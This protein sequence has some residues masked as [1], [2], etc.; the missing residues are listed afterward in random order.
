MLVSI[1][2]ANEYRAKGQ[3]LTLTYNDE[4]RP[5]GLKHSDFASFMKRLRFYDSTP[6]VKF[7]IA[8]EYGEKSGREHF[9]ILIYNH[10]YDLEQISRAWNKGFVY[11]GTLTPQSIKYVS[12]YVCKRGYNPDSGKRPPYG[13]TSV[14]LP[15]GMSIKEITRMCVTGKI[16][17][18]G[19]T[20][21]APAI[22]R[23]RYNDIWKFL[24]SERAEYNFRFEKKDLTP[25]Y[26][27]GIMNQRELK[28]ICK[29]VRFV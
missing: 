22:W 2:A 28:R 26:V 17:Y 23:R 5:Q 19:R 1:Y 21:A 7:H 16:L 8:G 27:S 24:E 15:D 13:R 9:H 29:K 25:E 12:G 6:G 3:F 14:N 10:R 20:F 18:N 11:D 4:N